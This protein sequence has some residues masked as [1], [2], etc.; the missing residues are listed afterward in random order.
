M[1]RRILFLLLLLA[2]PAAAQDGVVTLWTREVVKSSKLHDP[3]DIYVTTPDGYTAGTDRYS[4]LIILDANDK[5][6]FNLALANVAF[7]ANRNA[8]PSMIVVGIPNGKDRTHDL[9][10]TTTSADAKN[11]PTAGGAAQ[12]ADFIVDEVVPMVRSKYRTLPGI[13]LAGHSFGGLLALEVATKKAGSFT[14]VIAMSPAL[15]W[16]DASGV[17]A[18]SDAI[19]KATKPQRLFVTSGGLEPDIDRRTRQFEQRL[20]SL[21]PALTV[22]GHGRYENDHHGLTPAPSLVDGLRFVFEPVSVTNLPIYRLGPSSDSAGVV[23]AVL[24]SRRLYANGARLFGLD[25]RLPER[26]LNDVGYNVLAELKKPALA[27][28]VFKQNVDLYPER[29]NTYDSLGDGL[30]AAGDTTNAIAQFRRAVDVGTRFKQPVFGE[31]LRK[32]NA[33]EAARAAKPTGG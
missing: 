17:V 11:F 18:Y 12:F 33:L 9:T 8:I 3:R 14:G 27:V 22:F 19:S 25:E 21:K 10:P 16:N 30:L 20:D 7:L 1:E 13:V 2:S 32:L 15:W 23:S 5:T 29:A 4:V 6:Q 28:W 24:E 31:S 26:E